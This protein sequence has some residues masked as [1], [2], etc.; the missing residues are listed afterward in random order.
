MSRFQIKSWL[1]FNLSTAVLME[2]CSMNQHLAQKDKVKCIK[3]V[4][5]KS[6]NVSL[7]QVNTQIY[8]YFYYNTNTFTTM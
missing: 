3:K 1:G 4:Y 2:L 5:F 7:I 6:P 8:Q